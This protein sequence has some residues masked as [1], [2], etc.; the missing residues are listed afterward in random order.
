ME[1][2]SAKKIEKKDLLMKALKVNA[3]NE[4]SNQN[5]NNK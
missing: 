4:D 1:K 2:V 3:Q 5:V